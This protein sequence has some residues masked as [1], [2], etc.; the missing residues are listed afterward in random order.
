MSEKI[1][2]YNRR[3]YQLIKQDISDNGL[4]VYLYLQ[5]LYKENRTI[6]HCNTD[7]IYY[8]IT[9][10]FK[11]A[12]HSPYKEKIING[13]LELDKKNFI[14]IIKTDNKNFLINIEKLKE[15]DIINITKEKANPFS[16]NTYEEKEAVRNYFSLFNIEDIQ[17]CIKDNNGRI[18]IIRYICYILNLKAENNNN[19]FFKAT[20]D[21]LSKY[22]NMDTRTIDRYNK[23]LIKNKILYIKK[24]K[25]RYKDSKKTLENNYGLYMDRDKIEQSNKVY[26]DS[27][28]NIIEYNNVIDN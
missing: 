18:R 7:S 28:K 1:Y 12:H 2:F 27:I 11:I 8:F 23:I 13:I 20:R 9:N 21:D 16:E 22:C 15:P 5:Q 6:V 4:I 14:K 19:Y 10:K 17:Q 24:F 25:Y 26:I 3:G